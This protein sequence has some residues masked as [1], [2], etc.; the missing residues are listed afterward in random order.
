MSLKPILKKINSKL[1]LFHPKFFYFYLI[2]S[3]Y[4]SSYFAPI[5][6]FSIDHINRRL[7]PSTIICH[8]HPLPSATVHHYQLPPSVAANYHQPPPTAAGHHHNHLQ[9]LSATIYCYHLKLTAATSTTTIN[10][11]R[12]SPFAARAHHCLPP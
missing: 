4:F 9:P 11:H 7:L 12:L 6:F 5:F 1:V 3:H 8:C 10:Y 2:S